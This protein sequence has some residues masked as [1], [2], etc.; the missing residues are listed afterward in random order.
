ML[1]LPNNKLSSIPP[2]FGSGFGSSLRSL[3]LA[4]NYLKSL[5]TSL[6]QS[7][8]SV[9][10]FDVRF[11]LLENLNKVMLKWNKLSWLG[12]TG[13]YLT[14]LPAWLVEFTSLY[15]IHH[16][17]G[18]LHSY[19]ACRHAQVVTEEDSNALDWNQATLNMQKLRICMRNII[20]EHEFRLN[21]A[22]H[23]M[24]TFEDYLESIGTHLR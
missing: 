10:E 18:L 17:W 21:A 16:E 2:S 9:E 3:C 11:N 5:P 4:G 15:T 23:P 14:K 8:G 20:R 24:I 22:S 12:L 13:N 6:F 7:L 19:H 1:I